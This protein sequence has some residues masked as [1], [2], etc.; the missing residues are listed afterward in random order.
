MTALFRLTIATMLARKMWVVV[1]LVSIIVL[2]VHIL[3]NVV[4][5]DADHRR[6][7][8]ELVGV[9]AVVGEHSAASLATHLGRP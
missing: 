1:L 6:A 2:H 8:P 5:H 4:A 7:E 9:D 3:A